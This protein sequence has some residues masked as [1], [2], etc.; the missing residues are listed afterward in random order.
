VTV[1]SSEPQQV[2]LE[3]PAGQQAALVWGPDDGP[4]AVLL[5]GFPDSPWSWRTVAPALAG[6]GWRVVAPWTR[7]YAPSFV[8]ADGSYHVGALMADAVAV[9]AAMGGGADSVLLGHDWGAL[10]SNAIGAHPDSPFRRVVSMAVPP[11]TAIRRTPDPLL[12]LGQARRSWYIG[13]VQLPG[14]SERALERLVPRLWRDWSPGYDASAELPHA[15][16]AIRGRESAVLGY[17]RAMARPL[18][19]P[20]AYRSWHRTWASTPVVPTLYLHGADDGCLTP[21]FTTGLADQLPPGSA[22]HV[23][24]GAGH[25]LQLEQ[26]EDVAGHVLDF[27]EAGQT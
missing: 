27:L 8:P 14:V 17:Y 6:A 9:H 1:S 3:V 20:S 15:M 18:P 19:P 23:V 11:L 25:F 13:F 16:D 24:P 10:T 2:I 7:G 26:P 4:L 12:L 22:V 5:H 21:S